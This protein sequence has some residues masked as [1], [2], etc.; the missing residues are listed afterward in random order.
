MEYENLVDIA[1]YDVPEFDDEYKKMINDGTLDA[2]SGIH[3]VF[4]Y[5]FVPLVIDAINSDNQDLEKR[6][7]N[8]IEKMAESKDKKI[9]E[10]VDF[11]IMEELHDNIPT[12]KLV[13]LLSG[14]ESKRSLSCVLGYMN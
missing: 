7:F 6:L 4:S 5:V 12:E 11:T 8:F 3:I 1:R 9:S 2:D 13:S 10:V 14:D